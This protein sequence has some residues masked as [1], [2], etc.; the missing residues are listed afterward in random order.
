[1]PLFKEKESKMIVKTVELKLGA[2]CKIGDQKC[3]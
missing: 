1:M 3:T 2:N